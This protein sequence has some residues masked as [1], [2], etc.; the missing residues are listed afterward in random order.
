MMAPKSEL[1]RDLQ[2]EAFESGGYA[3]EPVIKLGP[4]REQVRL[5]FR[6]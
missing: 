2:R 6:K 1:G 4:S 3:S 5:D